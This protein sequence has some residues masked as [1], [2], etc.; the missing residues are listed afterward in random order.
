MPSYQIINQEPMVSD[1]PGGKAIEGQ[2]VTVNLIRDDMALTKDV[3]MDFLTEVDGKPTKVKRV[4]T[5]PNEAC[6][7]HETF[8]MPDTG[9]DE[10][11]AE[12]ERRA[13]LWQSIYNE[14]SDRSADT[15]E[16][17]KV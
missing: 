7:T 12:C 3:E 14:S 4:I 10:I 1:Q 2:K 11:P 8:F 17:V 15:I 6:I 5:V 13:K 16:T 9:A